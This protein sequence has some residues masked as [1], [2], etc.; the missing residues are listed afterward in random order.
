MSPSLKNLTGKYHQSKAKSSDVSPVLQLQGFN[1]L[2]AATVSKA[3]INIDITQKNDNEVQIKQSTTASIPAITEEWI[4]D[5]EWRE[6]GDA[7]LGKVRSRSRWRKAA[8][9][10]DEFLKEGVNGQEELVEA[11]V[12]SLEKDWKAQQAW[13]VEG[14]D[15]FVRRVV[16]TIKGGDGRV[17]TRLVY[18][19]QK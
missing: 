15:E 3:P 4:H 8:E 7:F 16:T 5:W 11:E 14:S 12:E 10:G 13:V 18:E 19:L 6:F 9:L 2:L 1:K 17:E